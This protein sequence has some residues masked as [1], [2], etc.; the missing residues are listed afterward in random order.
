MT[1]TH[2]SGEIPP[3]LVGSGLIARV[4][5]KLAPEFAASL[6]EAPF[7]REPDPLL[8]GP[9]DGTTGTSAQWPLD[10]VRSPAGANWAYMT[11]PVGC[12]KSSLLRAIAASAVEA[13]R[14]V[15]ALH[16]QTDN[17]P[18]YT[19]QGAREAT[20]V[21]EFQHL[22]KSTIRD[23]DQ[24]EKVL[25]AIVDGVSPYVVETIG[26]WCRQATQTAQLQLIC[27]TNW[28]EDDLFFPTWRPQITIQVD[29]KETIG[30][31][32][33]TVSRSSDQSSSPWESPLPTP[34]SPT[35]EEVNW[36]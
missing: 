33:G 34:F 5:R 12:G 13:G 8:V 31:V 11:G 10:L 28:T 17:A 7:P 35:I 24:P 22:I 15:V 26:T 29:E 30:F 6:T 25:L 18:S 2:T 19:A 1:T 20:D 14:P 23:S 16:L 21:T 4:L 27:A 32:T 9:R 36:P 3:V